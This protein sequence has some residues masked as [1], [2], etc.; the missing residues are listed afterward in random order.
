MALCLLTRTQWYALN[1]SVQ[2]NTFFFFSF[3]RIAASVL[4]HHFGDLQGNHS[5][6]T[7]RLKLQKLS[8]DFTSLQNL[9][10]QDFL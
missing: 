7:P 9:W 1:I 4:G 2:H 6:V 8:R 10:F 3:L 5:F